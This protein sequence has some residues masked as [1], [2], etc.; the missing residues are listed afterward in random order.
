[1]ESARSSAPDFV[2]ADL[3]LHLAVAAAAANPFLTPISTLIEVAL[4]AMLTISSPVEDTDQHA[5]SVA[6]HR[7]IV[8]AIAARNADL[9][10]EAMRT[11]INQGLERRN[12]KLR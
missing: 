3:H 2:Q 5:T 7:A 12:S 9:A 8:D 4:V 10:R 11:V 6:A 1:M